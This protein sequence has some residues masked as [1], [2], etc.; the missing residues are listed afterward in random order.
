MLQYAGLQQHMKQLQHRPRATRCSHG[1]RSMQCI[2]VV[3]TVLAE[4]RQGFWANGPH[5]RVCAGPRE[6]PLRKTVLRQSVSPG[7]V[8]MSPA[9]QTAN[10]LPSFH[11]TVAHLWHV[12]FG[13]H[14]VCTVTASSLLLLALL[15][16]VWRRK[17]PKRAP[18][19]DRQVVK[20]LRRLDPTLG[21][22]AA[23]VSRACDL[24]KEQVL[25]NQSSKKLSGPLVLN[26][27][28]ASR[29]GPNREVAMCCRRK[30]YH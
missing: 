20:V 4:S 22:V 27:L 12:P 14:L 3:A 30:A 15:V 21:L 7:A 2:V 6:A 5:R 11:T 19:S 29:P 13:R 10:N 24:M 28:V 18:G 17:V 1:L 23:A 8:A 16:M 26:L 9:G 25:A